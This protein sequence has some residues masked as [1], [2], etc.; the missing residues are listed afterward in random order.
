MSSS[1]K[2]ITKEEKNEKLEAKNERLRGK[3]SELKYKN[4][5]LIS[6]NR[7]LK[8]DNTNKTGMLKAEIQKLRLRIEGHKTGRRTFWSLKRP[9]SAELAIKTSPRDLHLK[10]RKLRP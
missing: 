1:A 7:K 10:A 2:L 4:D 8:Y 3:N 9:A 5:G 6:V